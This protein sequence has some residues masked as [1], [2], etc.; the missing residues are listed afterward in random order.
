MFPP[1]RS[2]GTH[3]KSMNSRAKMYRSTGWAQ[4]IS[5]Y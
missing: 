5:H 1:T 2:T 3:G 4:N